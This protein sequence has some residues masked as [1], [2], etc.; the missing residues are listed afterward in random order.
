[1]KNTNFFEIMGDL[2][3]IALAL[4]LAFVGWGITLSLGYVLGKPNALGK[5]GAVEIIVFWSPILIVLIPSI[6]R[7]LSDGGVIGA[8]W[9]FAIAPLVGALNFIP[10]FIFEYVTRKIV[11]QST[12]PTAIVSTALAALIWTLPYFFSSIFSFLF[13]GVSIDMFHDDR[14]ARPLRNTDRD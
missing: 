9:L 5:I 1:M 10:W 13:Q 11:G 7:R 6:V 4:V 12:F 2:I 8:I 14:N 3:A